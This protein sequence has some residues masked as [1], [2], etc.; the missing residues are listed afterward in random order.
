M[1]QKWTGCSTDPLS[2]AHFFCALYIATTFF[3]TALNSAF[4]SLIVLLNSA[5]TAARCF[6]TN[7]MYGFAVFFIAFIAFGAFAALAFMAFIAFIAAMVRTHGS[8]T[9]DKEKPLMF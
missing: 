2:A 9:P 8:E 7:S 4:L 6:L 3:P 5:W 1:M